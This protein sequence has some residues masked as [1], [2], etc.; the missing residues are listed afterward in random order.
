MSG[1][2]RRHVLAGSAAVLAA[3]HAPS[4][5]RPAPLLT[6]APSP[7]ET[8]SL[9]TG[10]RFH[11]GD[12][13]FPPILD[14]EAAYA[15]AK[16]GNAGGAAAADYDDSDWTALSIP[17]DWALGQPFDRTANIDQGFRRRGIGWYRRTFALDDAD[18]DRHLELRF[19]GIATH[20]TVWINGT[21]AHR[22]F[23]GFT[24]FTIDLGAFA[25]FGDDLNTLAIRVDAE[26]TEGWW[27]EGAGLYRHAW[28]V[29]R[30]PVHIA[31]DGVHCHPRRDGTAWHLPVAATIA[32][33]GARAADITVE[34]TLFDPDDRPIA[35]Q[36]TSVSVAPSASTVAAATIAV[37]APALWSP[38][39][40]TL[41]R[42]HTAVIANDRITDAVDTTIGFRTQRFDAQH[43]FFLNDRPLKIRGV[44]VHQDHAGVGVA[45]PDS[46]WDFRLRRLK[47]MGA[48]AIRCAHNPPAAELLDAADRLGMMVMDEHREL[49]AADDALD[50]LAWL[51]RRD[52]NHPSVILWS[53]CN[54][55]SLQASATGVAMIRR[56]KAVVRTLDRDRPITAALNG[57]MF[58]RPNIADELDV[59]GFNYGTAHYDRYHAAFPDRA[60]LSS[61][62]TSAYMT[63]GA[64]ATDRAAHVLA[65]DD[66]EH[67]GWGLSHREAWRSIA[68]RP[69]MAGGFAWTGFDY[70]GEPTPFDWPSTGA[71]FGAMD[72][73]GFAKSA[74]HIRRALWTPDQPVLELSPHWTWPGREG[75]AIALLVV[76]NADRV[77]LRL[78]GRIVADVAV[79]PFA[80]A[81]VT[82]PYA[83]GRLEAIGYRRG[84]PVIHRRVETAGVPVAL[85]LVP[86]RTVLAGDGRDTVPVTI[87]AVDAQA[88]AVPV[89]QHA[90]HL[91][92]E[93]GRILGVG[94]GDPNSHESDL[95]APGGGSASRRLFNGLAQ[96]LVQTD[97]GHRL[98][99]SARADGLSMAQ[100][101][102]AVTPH[103]IP[104]VA[105]QEGRQ[106]LTEWRQAPA[107]ATPPDIARPIA[108]GDM[109]SWA[110]L[111]PGSVE[112]GDP[113]AR[114]VLMHTDFVPRRHVAA[115]G[116]QLVFAALAG[117]AQLWIDGR[118]VHRKTDPAARRVELPFPSGAASRTL[119]LL[120]DTGGQAIPF[121]LAGSVTVA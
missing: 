115:T 26:A 78:N 4:L 8:L 20:C 90:V 116:G 84:L 98:T 95:P 99:L 7:R 67:A 65:D 55:E 89:A 62:D 33:T 54:E 94:N 47:E 63:R 15:H 14:H 121:G 37:T 28:L 113:A 105:P 88:R 32:N 6:N 50:R 45:V 35:R 92:V 86:D 9:D 2:S 57:A 52:R 60:L 51:I 109:N 106:R 82:I 46:L 85:R 23:S 66:S 30:D 48:N 27:Y 38:D 93:G 58:A 41:Y 5:A 79:D 43:G 44:C 17:H 77:V 97:G 3:G 91:H 21:L 11:E 19:D 83:P 16:A 80:M 39:R 75:Q 81:R 120:F 29:K 100:V 107:S 119:R 114:Y 31:T 111:K 36:R 103:T 1:P 101:T 24:G 49:S 22:H 12:L 104:T 102:L 117:A 34:A 118:L 96:V 40:P 61:E 74:F 71:S 112:T 13:P 59:V 70:R 25:L 64:L 72:Q 10:W 18:R 69:F 76:A 68:T 87:E 73:S 108:E 110:W 53:L 56:M 42:L